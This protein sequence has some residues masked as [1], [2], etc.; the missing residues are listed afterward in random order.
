MASKRDKLKISRQW[1][2]PLGRLL[3]DLLRKSEEEGMTDEQFR[4]ELQIAYQKIPS[5]ILK[6]DITLLAESIAE[7]YLNAFDPK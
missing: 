6:L 7:Q 2:D 3:I 1:L 4:R 5:L